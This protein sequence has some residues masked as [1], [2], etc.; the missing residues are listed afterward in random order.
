MDA[1]A[2]RTGMPYVVVRSRTGR[3][4]PAAISVSS[5][6]VLA[7]PCSEPAIRE[8]VSSISVPP[9]SSAPACSIARVPSAPSLTQVVWMWS[10]AAVQHDPGEGVDGQVVAQ[11]RAGPGDAG[12]VDRRGG[13]HERQRHELGEPAAV[14]ASWIRL[15]TR[16]CGDPV[17]R[18]VDV[19]VHHRRAR[20]GCP[21]RCAVVTT[22]TQV[23]AGSLPLVSTHRTSSS[24]ISAAVP[25]IVSSPASWA[26]TRKSWT[27]SPVRWRR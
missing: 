9:R 22:S 16:R 1:S 27:D 25:G 11:R 12:E 24:R 15:S 5:A 2:V 8:I 17:A 7:E 13:V 10:I 3:P 26:L 20:R 19:A 6:T 18:V 14:A 4:M 23:L 21:S